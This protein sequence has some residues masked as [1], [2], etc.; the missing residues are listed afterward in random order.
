MKKYLYILLIFLLS[1]TNL[2][3][4][5]A[6]N[7]SNLDLFD[8]YD[9][10]LKNVNFSSPISEDSIINIC[11][12]LKAKYQHT[13]NIDTIYGI[14]EIEINSLCLKGNM[15]LAINKANLM[16]EDAKRTQNR[17]GIG[18]AFQAIGE[19]YLHS[20]QFQQAKESFKEAS[21][22]IEETQIP[23]AQLRLLIQQMYV[24]MELNDMPQLQRSIFKA[25]EASENIR[26]RSLNDIN[27]YISCYQT[28]H[29]IGT[30]E[31]TLASEYLR[32]T[33]EMK[34]SNNYY[35][36]WKFYIN[37]RYYELTKN[38]EQALLYSDS[39]LQC[40]KHKNPNAYIK[41]S[42]QKAGLYEK[43]NELKQ[44]CDVYA[45]AN[46]LSDSL[47][48]TQY[49]SQVDSLRVTYWVDQMNIENAVSYN[50]MLTMIMLYGAIVLVVVV[51]LISIARKKNRLLH[52]SQIRLGEKR[53][54]ASDSIQSKSL[55]LSNMSHEL[56]TPLSTIVSFSGLLA[57]NYE[58]DGIAAEL[59]QQC[60]EIINKNSDLLFKRLNDITDISDLGEKRF[61]FTWKQLDVIALCRDV[62]AST[63]KA[64]G[65]PSVVFHFKT[66]LKHLIIETDEERLRQVLGNLLTNASKFT[67]KGYITLELN[68]SKED[69]KD[70]AEFTIE[71]TGCGIPL[72]KQSTIF[73]RFE[74]LHEQVQGIGLGLPICQLIVTHIGG[75]IGLDSSYKHGARFCFTHPIKRP[76]LDESCKE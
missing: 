32:K 55:F 50:R 56:R 65:K 62:M 34:F 27:F 1:H 54:E 42:I 36:V 41:F 60:T 19:T 13:E 39:V 73:Q 26:E 66:D 11:I 59:K 53:Y 52:Q 35:D 25:I 68:A 72:N 58:G 48:V 64:E 16:Y 74:K 69:G 63:E 45:E 3:S 49:T 9:I 8:L 61:K 23:Y 14:S 4:K 71:D 15:G 21:K 33:L 67:T 75:K 20:N 29:A 46:I 44:A 57:D 18:L 43:R 10:A 5:E 22:Y 76:L 37:S 24:F 70:F 17:L 31:A 28:L 12:N 6:P 7:I 51:A 40:L 30:G 2:E 38:Y 47:N